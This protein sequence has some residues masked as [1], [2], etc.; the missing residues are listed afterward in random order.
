MPTRRPYPSD[1]SDARWELIEPVLAAWR[2]ERRGRA[3]DFG[4]PPEHDLRDIMDAI[5]YVDRT[6]VQWRYLPHDFPPW[7]TVYGYFAKWQQEGVFAQLNGLLRQ[8]LRQKE[9]RD[10][11]PSA[12][13]IDAQSVKTSTS[14][15][16]SGQGVDAG[17][18]IVG[19]K[20]SIV[21]DTIGLL[22]AVLV[23]AASVQDSVAGTQLLDQVSAEHPGIRKVWVDGG[24]R[25]HLVEHA[26]AL[27]IDMEITART[28]GTR[29][30]TPI[31]KR[32]A[33]ERTYGWLM[34]HRRLARD[35]ETLPTR[36][37]A[38][39]HLA[40]TD[41]M[42]RRLTG[43]ATISWRDPTPQTKQQIPG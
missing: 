30:F 9:G 4:R 33:V 16:S 27:G 29:G 8:L 6:G 38:M 41:L 15:P 25:R 1:L 20:R 12:C 28:P 11:E 24:Y 40:M 32:W 42:A 26:A 22:L 21:V 10:T 13:V 7:N 2:F 3:L 19:R 37:E 18:K 35:Y 31:P 17:K 23:T 36:S 34:L 5:L 39:I 43:E 14:V